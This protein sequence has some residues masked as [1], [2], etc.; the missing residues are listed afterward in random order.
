MVEKLMHTMSRGDGD[1]VDKFI[2]S[3]RESGQGH[4]VTKFLRQP[5][6]SDQWKSAGGY[7]HVILV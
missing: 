7:N 1:V 6:K 3:L 4:V 5:H 2:F